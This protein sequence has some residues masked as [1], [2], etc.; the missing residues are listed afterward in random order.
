[1]QPARQRRMPR[2]PRRML[3]K[4]REDILRDFLRQPRIAHPPHRRTKHQPRITPEQRAKRGFIAPLRPC[5]KQMLIGRFAH[6]FHE[7]CLSPPK[8]NILFST[9]RADSRDRTSAIPCGNEH[10]HG[11]P[12]PQRLCPIKTPR[13]VS[14]L[15]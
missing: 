6:G 10:R 7:N 13:S 14:L 15:K 5:G 8:P 12:P 2:E 9:A 1:M 3:R 11:K 4:P